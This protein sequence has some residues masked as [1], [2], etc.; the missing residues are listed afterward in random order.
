VK[1]YKSSSL[2]VVV[3]TGAMEEPV[4]MMLLDA[5]FTDAP[6]SSPATPPSVR[7]SFLSFDFFCLG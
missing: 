3:L 5:I 7:Q 1:Q 4:R 2:E 6:V